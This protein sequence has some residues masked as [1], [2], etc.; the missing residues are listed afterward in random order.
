MLFYKSFDNDQD[1]ID[2]DFEVRKIFM[3]FLEN[4][5]VSFVAMLLQDS[6]SSIND[7]F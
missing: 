3:R 6:L 5:D 2:G 1:D 7:D 4:Y